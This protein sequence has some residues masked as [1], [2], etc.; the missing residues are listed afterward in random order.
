MHAMASTKVACFT[1]L[2]PWDP[3]HSQPS[4]SRDSW[5]T[6]ASMLGITTSSDRHLLHTSP[7]WHLLH[8][9]CLAWHLWGKL[10]FS[11][12]LNPHHLCQLW[13]LIHHTVLIQHHAWSPQYTHPPYM[14]P[15]TSLTVCANMNNTIL[16]QYLDHHTPLHC[17]RTY[18]I[19]E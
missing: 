17:L 2:C 7:L 9:L 5:L 11:L 8:I 4:S 18:T 3:L 16:S 1:C 10:F 15:G 12:C 6:I 14:T 13:M 19:A